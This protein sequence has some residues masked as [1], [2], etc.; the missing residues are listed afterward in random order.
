MNSKTDKIDLKKKH[1]ELDYNVAIEILQ[2][3]YFVTKILQI[4]NYIEDKWLKDYYIKIAIS[5]LAI[6]LHECLQANLLDKRKSNK[7]AVKLLDRIR[8][9]MI[10]L[11]PSTSSESMKHT[12]DT[13]G[14][15]FEHYIFDLQLALNEKMQNELYDIG[16][17]YYDLLNGEEEL[18]VF[19]TLTIIPLQII[20]EVISVIPLEISKTDFDL[21]FQNIYMSLGNSVSNRVS[22]RKYPY[23][24]GVFFRDNRLKW[25]DKIVVLYYYTLVKQALLLDLLIPDIIGQDVGICDTLNSKCKFRAIIIENIGLFLKKAS[26]PLADELRTRINEVMDKSFF[27]KN[28]SIRNNIHYNRISAYCRD[29][30]RE[31]YLQQET[32][33]GAVL[34][35]LNSKIKY[36]VGWKYKAIKFIAEKTDST[37]LDIR[38]NNPELKHFEDVSIEEWDAA[39]KR[40]NQKNNKHR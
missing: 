25:N 11:V 8:Q 36:Q 29:D 31:L 30:I 17:T 20:E 21:I 16:F 15:D 28:R 32:Y 7:K 13:M 22:L 40:L 1:A 38:R 6:V 27:T 35:I 23:A 24:S 39:K 37:M 2:D 19:E 9:R 34:E 12:V 4:Q 14:I 10:K 33:L 18:E 5:Y 26:T 3:M